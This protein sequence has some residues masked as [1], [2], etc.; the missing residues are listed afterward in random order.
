MAKYQWDETLS[1]G[2]KLIDQQ[3]KMLIQRLDD[4]DAAIERS[5]GEGVIVKTISFLMDYTNFHFSTEEKN[6]KASNY[7]GLEEHLKAHKELIR[8]LNDLEED[9]REEGATHLL[10][11]ALNT[12]LNNWLI[13]HIKNVDVRF[14]KFLK[15]EGIQIKE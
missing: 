7:P 13:T 8:T 3:H 6:M 5:K 11:A 12:F 2:I 9:F 1:V 10:A 4:V 15:E 14:G